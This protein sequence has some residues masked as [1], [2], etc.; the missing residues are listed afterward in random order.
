VNA[1][2]A[3]SDEPERVVCA[4]GAEYQGPQARDRHATHYFIEKAREA[5]A[6]GRQTQ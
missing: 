1:H 4:C 6:E 5:L 2:D 3:I